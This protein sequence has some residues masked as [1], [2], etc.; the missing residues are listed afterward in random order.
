[1]AVFLPELTEIIVSYLD[2]QSVC[3]LL[4]VSRAVAH[5][6][7][8]KLW[9]DFFGVF[10]EFGS[11]RARYLSVVHI[12]FGSLDDDC[13]EI[14]CDAF[15]IDSKMLEKKP[16]FD[17]LSFLRVLDFSSCFKMFEPLSVRS[18]VFIDEMV[19]N[20][21][22]RTD[23][24]NTLIIDMTLINSR[25]VCP[26]LRKLKGRKLDLFHVREFTGLE[27]IVSF[28]SLAEL[29]NGVISVCDIKEMKVEEELGI[30]TISGIPRVT[31]YG[32]RNMIGRFENV[33]ELTLRNIGVGGKNTSN[34]NDEEMLRELNVPVLEL[35][36]NFPVKKYYKVLLSNPRIKRFRIIFSLLD[37][38]GRSFLKFAV[39][40]TT[41]EDLL[42]MI[43]DKHK[44]IYSIQM[45]GG[46]GSDDEQLLQVTSIFDTDIK[47]VLEKMEIDYHVY[48]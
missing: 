19:I 23:G 5:E 24:I 34:A 20:M 40:G 47:R 15:K 27:S 32:C 4:T 18:R 9:S 41:F 28:K 31:L 1:M 25:V 21:L 2:L 17:Y 46:W 37:S 33:Q 13:K 45:H 7:A 48:T 10:S 8:R 22:S 44:R 43:R 11:L 16:Y 38:V 30:G 35:H 26:L 14:V 3:M 12:L 39:N 6:C 36:I 29:V 42:T